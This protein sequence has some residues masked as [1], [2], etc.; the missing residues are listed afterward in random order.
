MA[1]SRNGRNNVGHIGENDLDSFVRH[2]NHAY[3]RR[4]TFKKT[5]VFLLSA[6]LV[7]ALADLIS[8]KLI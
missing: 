1:H 4:E 7:V 8:A 3:Y 5:L 2:V 6:I